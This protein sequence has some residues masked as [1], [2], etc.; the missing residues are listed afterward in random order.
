MT[1]ITCTSGRSCLSLQL[2]LLVLAWCLPKVHSWTPPRPS[3]RLIFRSS[4]GLHAHASS[5]NQ[6]ESPPPLLRRRI[7]VAGMSVSPNGFWVIVQSSPEEYWPIQV[8][9]SEEDKNLSVESLTLLQLLNGVDMAG[10]VLPPELLSRLA[11]EHAEDH[12]SLQGLLDEIALPPDTLYSELSEWQKARIRLPQVTLDAVEIILE[13]DNNNSTFK[14]ML[15]CQSPTIGGFKFSPETTTTTSST[16][17]WAFICV[18][19]ALRYQAPLT[20]KCHENTTKAF[21]LSLQNVEQQFPLFTTT[22]NLRTAADRLSKNLQQGFEIHKLTGALKM[23]MDR[24]DIKAIS[25]IREKLDEYDS[26]EDLPT[27]PN[28]DYDQLQ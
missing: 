28:T 21:W 1:P 14:W 16:T 18:A 3:L 19:L 22:Q 23:A 2:I 25:R 9:E 6:D 24:G 17:H 4:T 10:P 7:S 26:F 15:A 27:L 13:D 12:E 5:S 20:M 11:V 8:T